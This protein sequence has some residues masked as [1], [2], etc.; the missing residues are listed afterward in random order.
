[1]LGRV[2]GGGLL[3]HGDGLRCLF[4]L[5]TIHLFLVAEEA[6]LAQVVEGGEVV[7]LVFAEVAVEAVLLHDPQLLADT[8]KLID[9][10]FA[11]LQLCE[12]LVLGDPICEE[13]VTLDHLDGPP[14]GGV[15]AEH[16]P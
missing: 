1:M 4:L 16:P 10:Y 14:F 7:V 6:L 3:R 9:F 15:L 5:F 8:P 2:E 12:S 11:H 13:L